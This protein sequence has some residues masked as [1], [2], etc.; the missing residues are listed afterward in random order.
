MFTILFVIGT[1]VP[2]S[3]LCIPVSMDL[4]FIRAF[5]I[6]FILWAFSMILASTWFSW[7]VWRRFLGL[8]PNIILAAMLL[9]GLFRWSP[10]L[11]GQEQRQKVEREERQRQEQAQQQRHAEEAAISKALA[12]H[13]L[14][15]FNEPLQGREELELELY[16]SS[17]NKFAPEKLIAASQH[18]RTYGIMTA[19][20]G[21]ATCPKEALEILYEHA[22]SQEKTGLYS[23]IAMEQLYSSIIG[24]P[25]ASL[26]LVLRMLHG[27]SPAARAAAVRNGK[28]P[29]KDKM[30]YLDKGCASSDDLEL[31]M[32]AR[33]EDTP[34]EVLECLAAKPGARYGLAGNPHT[35]LSVLEKMSQS[36]DLAIANQGRQALARRQRNAK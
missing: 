6:G 23:E 27:D 11:K 7:T 10:Y 34:V 31:S 17:A 28:L 29:L 12:Q 32:I 26:D 25:N 20:A 36:T 35:P 14:L 30:A 1:A 3:L 2:V 4:A 19:L 9:C 24:N 16:I 21:K 5:K 15:A 13:G 18:Y 33:D 22:A 8:L